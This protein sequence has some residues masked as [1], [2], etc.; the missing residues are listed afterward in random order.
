[1]AFPGVVCYYLFNRPIRTGKNGTVFVTGFITGALGIVLGAIVLGLALLASTGEFLG[2][3]KMVFIAH[4]PVMII[5]GF[6]T[7]AIVTFL[8]KVR[9]E[10]LQAPVGGTAYA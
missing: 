8:R 5:E 7:G 3:V 6:M 9:P 1:M 2:V 4:V 10:L